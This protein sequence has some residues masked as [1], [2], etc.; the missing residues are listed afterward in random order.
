VI[1]CNASLCHYF[2]QFSCNIPTNEPSSP[3]SLAWDIY[4]LA[5]GIFGKRVSWWST[6]EGVRSTGFW[7][8]WYLDD[9]H[10]C[11]MQALESGW[12]EIEGKRRTVLEIERGEEDEKP[13]PVP[14]K[15]VGDGKGVAL[16]HR[17]ADSGVSVSSPV[18]KSLPPPPVEMP[19]K[20]K[21][22]S[23]APVSGDVDSSFH[24][25]RR[26]NKLGGW[27]FALGPRKGGG[28]REDDVNVV[29]TWHSN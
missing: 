12:V 5:L 27:M 2:V 17:R 25:P 3:G 29:Q 7:D 4:E 22:G 15:V 1:P 8:P 16:T 6:E 9:M 10:R 21:L 26:R 28:E 19:E 11:M 20:K 13:P 24:E 23:E 14:P 18:F